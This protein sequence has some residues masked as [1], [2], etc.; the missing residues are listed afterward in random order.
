MAVFSLPC[1]RSPSLIFPEEGQRGRIDILI[2]VIIA[3]TPL[4]KYAHL[5]FNCISK[6]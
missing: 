1:G 3:F 4:T 2:F 6:D 5:L